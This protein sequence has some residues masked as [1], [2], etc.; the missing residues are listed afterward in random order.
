[1][2]KLIKKKLLFICTGNSCRSQIA[3]GFAKNHLEKYQVSSGGTNPETVN[4]YAIKVMNKIG[5]NI[6]NH[7]SKKINDDEFNSFDLIITLCGNA[8]DQCPVISSNKH[9]HW[10]ITD[11]AKYK[12]N[13]EELIIKYSKIR[14]IIIGKIKLLKSELDKQNQ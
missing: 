13:D 8:K 7:K 12:G 6:S 11:P 1:M 9:I 4:P 2:S 3:E 14:D 5:I 10:G